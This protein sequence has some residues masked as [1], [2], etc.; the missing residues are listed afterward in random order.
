MSRNILEELKAFSKVDV[1]EIAPSDPPPVNKNE[2][3]RLINTLVEQIK[4]D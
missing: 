3:R 4:L 2:T 1:S